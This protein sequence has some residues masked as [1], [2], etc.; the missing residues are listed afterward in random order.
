M[1]RMSE[2]ERLERLTKKSFKIQEKKVLNEISDELMSVRGVERNF[3][4]FYF[5]TKIYVENF[6]ILI[7]FK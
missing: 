7:N 2:L 6:K 1:N 5:L 4:N 3:K